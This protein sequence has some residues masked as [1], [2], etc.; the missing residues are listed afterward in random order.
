MKSSFIIFSYLNLKAE[1]NEI[2]EEWLNHRIHLLEHISVTSLKNQTDRDFL[3]ILAIAKDTPRSIRRRI[4]EILE[5]ILPNKHELL[6]VAPEQTNYPC[7]NSA[8]LLEDKGTALLEPFVEPDELGHVFTTHIGT[9]DALARNFVKETRT[10]YDWKK[11][12]HHGFINFTGGYVCMTHTVDFHAVNDTD[13]FIL[14][15]REPVED[16][17]GVLYVPHSRIHRAS[18]VIHPPSR[19]PMW[20]KAVHE[21]NIG[22]YKQWKH[23]FAKKIIQENVGGTH[24]RK[25]FDIN[26]ETITCR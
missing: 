4:R 23:S 15:L 9:D 16:F 19:N 14:T 7:K 24:V 6:L 2:T 3:Y 8:L 13:Y 10:V 11:Y 25:L 17:K 21:N 20:I 18:P 5:R 22:N 1:N 12:P 26:I